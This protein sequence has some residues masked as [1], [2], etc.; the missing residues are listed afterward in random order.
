VIHQ[1]VGRCIELMREHRCSA[2]LAARGVVK[3]AEYCAIDGEALAEMAEYAGASRADWQSALREGLL[4]PVGLARA[5][6][7]AISG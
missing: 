6:G 3:Y 5:V 4:D 7:E 1:A 2:I